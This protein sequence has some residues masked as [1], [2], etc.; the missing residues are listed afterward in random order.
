MASR[1]LVFFHYTINQI[2]EEAHHK[3]AL[4]VGKTP[5][6]LIR[7]CCQNS[8][9]EKFEDAL[10]LCR[11]KRFRTNG[12]VWAI[13]QLVGVLF[14][15][16]LA[17]E[18][19]TLDPAIGLAQRHQNSTQS[20]RKCSIFGRV[21]HFEKCRQEVADHITSDVAVR[22]GRHDV[23]VKFGDSVLNSDRIIQLFASSARFTH[24]CAVFNCILQPTGSS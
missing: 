3:V 23:C 1:S 16:K 10:H 21:L 19:S 2:V 24:F 18:Q 9:L 4:G 22:L 20:R 5:R 12:K 11:K 6:H 14:L 8:S 17:C 13:Q 7:K 15:R